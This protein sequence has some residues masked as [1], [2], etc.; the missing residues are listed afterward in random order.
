MLRNISIRIKIAVTLIVVASFGLVFYLI[1]T[2]Y[3]NKDK[4]L[5]QYILQVEN[6][7]SGIY[8]GLQLQ[9]EFLLTDTETEDFHLNRTCYTLDKIQIN[10]DSLKRET[11]FLQIHHLT[12]KFQLTDDVIHLRE[13]LA[14]HEQNLNELVSKTLE[15]GFYDYGKSGEMRLYIH[16]L[17]DAY[18][19]QIDLAKILQ[20]RRHEKD[21]MLRHDLKYVDKHKQLSE[22]IVQDL[23]RLEKRSYKASKLLSQYSRSFYEYVALDTIIGFGASN[24]I[25]K[26]IHINSKELLAQLE[27]II[28]ETKA[29]ANSYTKNANLWFM[30]Y[31]IIFILILA[32]TIYYFARSLSKPILELS[33]G[34]NAFIQKDYQ[35]KTIF[36]TA[37]RQ[38]EIGDLIRSFENLQIEISDHFANYRVNSK[39]RQEELEKQREKLRIQKFLVE[40][41]RNVLKE[42][43]ETFAESVRYANKIQQSILPNRSK[44][45]S[46]FGKVGI[47]YLPKDIVSGDFY[48]AH[49][50]K[51]YK[52][53]A[54]GDCTGHG[55]PGAFMSLLGISYL[56]YGVKDKG[57]TNTNDLLNYLNKKVAEALGQRGIESGLKDGMDIAL[58]RIDKETDELQFSGAQRELFILRAHQLNELQ[59]DKFPI[60]WILPGDQKEFTSQT[61]QLEENDLIMLY[62][63]GLIDQFGGPKNKKFKRVQLKEI[64]AKSTELDVKGLTKTIE[65]NVLSWQGS[66]NQTD[67]ISLL[68]FRHQ[69]KRFEKDNLIEVEERSVHYTSTNS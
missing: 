19:D 17:E 39:R 52:Y 21:Y 67:D 32:I 11:N 3:A 36:R 50:D 53:A 35:E 9:G 28:N 37:N 48:W 1:R 63:D 69:P 27:I 46:I 31:A 33:K 64:I 49:E 8:K 51:R 20:L 12:D 60:G 10:L 7:K 59:P 55:V 34:I 15:R 13:L 41:S 22:E 66:T 68:M 14:E 47:I 62:T 44:L 18:I 29:N 58:V 38:D 6:I 26:S 23:N 30:L 43:N 25:R 2:V 54:V 57:K 5:D 4:E 16:E 56:N 40:E 24:G 45:N 42:Q 61:I 65:S